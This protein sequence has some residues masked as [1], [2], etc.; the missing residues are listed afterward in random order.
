MNKTN[1]GSKLYCKSCILR[2]FL[3]NAKDN[4]NGDI[5]D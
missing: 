1:K 5:K 4:R 3:D 2:L